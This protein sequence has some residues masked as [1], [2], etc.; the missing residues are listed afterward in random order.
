MTQAFNSF[1]SGLPGATTLTGTELIPLIQGGASSQ[2]TPSALK[3]YLTSAVSSVSG[4][5]SANIDYG[6]SPPSGYVAGVTNRLILT[7]SANLSVLGLL[8]APDGWAVLIK[9][10]SATYSI[11]FPHHGAGTSTNQFDNASAASVVLP[12]L[13]AALAN[14]VVNEWTFS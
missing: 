1:V 12:P 3:T 13:G 8:S 5:P 14:Y 10:A 4:T 11:T 6:A 7:P 9:N 2:S